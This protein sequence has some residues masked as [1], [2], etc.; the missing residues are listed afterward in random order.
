MLILSR[1]DGE[2]IV[3]G[4]G[5]DTI[6]VVVHRDGGNRVRIGIDA[7]REMPIVDRNE[8]LIP[9]T[10][11]TKD[12]PARLRQPKCYSDPQRSTKRQLAQMLGL[13]KRIAAHGQQNTMGALPAL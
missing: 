4:S 5:K 8:R 6:H 12:D 7:P 10:R 11:M 2:E 9:K 3:I 1:K 13:W